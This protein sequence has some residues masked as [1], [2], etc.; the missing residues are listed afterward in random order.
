MPL[1][2]FQLKRIKPGISEKRKKNKYLLPFLFAIISATIM[3][4]FEE[5]SSLFSEKFSEEHF[6]TEPASL[7]DPNRY[8]L[9]LGGKRVR[10]VLC[11]MGNE[12]FEVIHKDAWNAA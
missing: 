12:L 9:K 8:F 7:Y 11:L 1:K 6:P 5:L 10:P 3:H 2:K 4:S